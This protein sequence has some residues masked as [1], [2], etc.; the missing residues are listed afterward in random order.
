MDERK[1]PV[2][3]PSVVLDVHKLKMC[4]KTRSRSRNIF[5]G[6]H[7][8]YSCLGNGDNDTVLFGL[9]RMNSKFFS[10]IGTAAMRWSD[11]LIIAH[12]T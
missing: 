6:N 10:S 12:F 2:K 11:F 4:P 1:N 7:S 9:V 5:F 8:F 3:W